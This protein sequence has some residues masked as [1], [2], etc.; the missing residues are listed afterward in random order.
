MNSLVL[1][2]IIILVLFYF[3]DNSIDG[4]AFYEK[5]SHHSNKILY[6]HEKFTPES[7]MGQNTICSKNCCFSGWPNSVQDTD[8]V[9]TINPEDIGTKYTTSND[10]CNNGFFTGCVCKEI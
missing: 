6:K 3:M 9:F 7:S 1:L 8:P 5:I 10:T 2:L 4:D